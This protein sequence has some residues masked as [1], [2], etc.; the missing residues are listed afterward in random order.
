MVEVDSPIET[1]VPPLAAV[2]CPDVDI[3]DVPHFET[4]ATELIQLVASANIS[5]HAVA[6]FVNNEC[7][8]HII[9]FCDIH[10]STG[11]DVAYY[12][13]QYLYII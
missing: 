7:L 9:I 10:A 4:Y 12:Y 6:K 1:V 3:I 2:V 5:T 8:I 13:C 11:I